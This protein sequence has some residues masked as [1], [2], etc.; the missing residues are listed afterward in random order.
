VLEVHEGGDAANPL[1]QFVWDVRY[2]DA[3]VVRFHDGDTNGT[4]DDTLYYTTDANMNVTALVDTDGHVVE[5]YAYDAYGQV[6][7]LHGADDADGAVTEWEEDTGGS[8]WDNRVLYAGYRFDPETGLYHVRHRVY[9]AT[10]GRWIQRDPAGYVDGMNFA[11]YVAATPLMATDPLGLAACE[12]R[13]V[14]IPNPHQSDRFLPPGYLGRTDLDESKSLIVKATVEYDKPKKCFRCVLEATAFVRSEILPGLPSEREVVDS[15]TEKNWRDKVSALR[16]ATVRNIGTGVLETSARAV[17]ENVVTRE[18]V[19]V[20]EYGVH[21]QQ[22]AR[23]AKAAWKPLV[24]KTDAANWRVSKGQQADQL[25]CD[26]LA[27][28]YQKEWIANFVQLKN[29]FAPK[30]PQTWRQKIEEPAHV[31]QQK[32]LNGTAAKIENKAR[33]MGWR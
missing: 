31:A 8:D 30:D 5:R 29:S 20:H 6:T 10:L 17:K 33:Q 25:H 28:R 4:I 3:P 23:W 11:E 7:V 22:A 32:V 15:A 2:I 14:S 27:K 19:E 1:K 16:G 24:S 21:V 9:H 18:S 13:Q 26:G 12:V